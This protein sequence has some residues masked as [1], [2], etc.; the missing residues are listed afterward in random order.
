MTAVFVHGVPETPAVWEPL[1]E[2]LERADIALLQMP[3][4]GCALPDGFEPTMHGY[5][6]WMTD[7]L[8]SFDQVDLVVHD[9]GAL[10]ALRVL[11]DQPAN[12]RSW[13]TDMGDLGSD[14]RWHDTARTWQTPGDGE[15]LMDGMVAASET[16]RAALLA[17]VGVPEPHSLTMAGGIDATMGTAILALYRSATDIGN[18]W[19]PGIDDIRGSG[20][21]IASM[22]DPFR[23]VDRA[24]R[25]A[26]RTRADLVELP[27]TGHFW[28]L[29][30]P[31][32]CAQILTEHWRRLT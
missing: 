5:A 28:M 6:A 30:Q 21:V 32:R 3:G 7:E 4:F 14:F 27:D 9:W 24:R 17:A 22:Q 2:H 16:D 26:E 13:I 29:E 23:N 20:L 18:E 10:L 19:G 31:Q 12:V 15:A 8:T 25:L 1:V 11:A